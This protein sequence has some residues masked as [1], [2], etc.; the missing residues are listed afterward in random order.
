M[1][2]AHF[3]SSSTASIAL[4]CGGVHDG[5]PHLRSP[6]LREHPLA[7]PFNCEKIGDHLRMEDI[8]AFVSTVECAIIG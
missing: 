6:Q 5:S 4:L 2:G 8:S 1:R 7:E 3:M